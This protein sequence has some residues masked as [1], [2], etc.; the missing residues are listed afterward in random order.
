MAATPGA[1]L[2]IIP[3][4]ALVEPG[5]KRPLALKLPLPAFCPQPQPGNRRKTPLLHF[6]L[7]CRLQILSESNLLLNRKA[8][9]AKWQGAG[10][11]AAPG[12][13]LD[14]RGHVQRPR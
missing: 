1:K 12:S 7:R 8:A 4:T 14:D 10:A 13:A 9:H 3:E 5:A 11:D 2:V 6:R